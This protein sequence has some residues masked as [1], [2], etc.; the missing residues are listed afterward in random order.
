[1][2]PTAVLVHGAFED[3]ASWWLVVKALK[4]RNLPV[5]VRSIPLR[6]L[7]A[8]ADYLDRALAAV[9][10]PVLLV[11]HHY[12]GAVI[13]VA[14]AK[15][16]DTVGLVY[17]AASIPDAGESV[18]ETL[19]HPS[20][21]ELHPPGDKLAALP[22]LACSVAPVGTPP[23]EDRAV[24]QPVRASIFD[25]P[26][27]AAARSD[28]PSWAIVAT[29]DPAIDADVQRQMAAR[30]GA[31]TYELDAAHAVAVSHTQAVAE[32]IIRAVRATSAEGPPVNASS[33]QHARTMH[34]TEPT[35]S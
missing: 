16:E 21:E 24:T 4:A 12:G 29:R 17:V 5:L 1:M 26:A 25:E 14:A 20:G 35:Y 28:L 27:R 9:H 18:G 11:G 30:A 34:V 3:A 2:P 22:R 15:A 23:T 31:I 19:A 7:S 10:G 8:D 32:V 6:G 13:S 33:T